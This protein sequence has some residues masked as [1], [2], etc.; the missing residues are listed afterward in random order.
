MKYFI[1][2]IIALVVACNPEAGK[3]IY[4]SYD[5]AGNPKDRLELKQPT[6]A[7]TA[8]SLLIGSQGTIQAI[9]SGVHSPPTYTE[10]KTV[11]SMMILGT[12]CA[13]A[14]I[15]LIVG[16]KW[17]PL[18][19]SNAPMGCAITSAISF[20]YPT[21]LNE[22]KLPIFIAGAIWVLWTVYSFTHNRKLLKTNT[23]G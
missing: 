17:F 7:N 1:L 10:K 15:T 19:P 8:G 12:L 4:T 13:L 5:D 23:K 18:I 3:A 22:Y 14:A 21:I 16:K 2:L 20:T 11:D 6:S 9:V